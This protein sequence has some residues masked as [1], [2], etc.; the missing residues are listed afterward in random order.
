MPA[1]VGVTISAERLIAQ[2][3]QSK[4]RT[5]AERLQTSMVRCLA[6]FAHKQAA[7]QHLSY[8]SLFTTGV[9]LALSWHAAPLWPLEPY[10]HPGK[11]I[12]TM[13]YSVATK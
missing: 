3:A 13:L 6:E 12:A 10:V 5:A 1:A 7:I 8:L 4:G 2:V 11:P 9:C